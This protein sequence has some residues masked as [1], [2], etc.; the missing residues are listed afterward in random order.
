M[1]NLSIWST[2]DCEI[3]C[4]FMDIFHGSDKEHQQT[5]NS[6]PKFEK[7]VGILFCT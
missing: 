2:I 5:K 7:Y 1:L 6:G 4:H 3:F